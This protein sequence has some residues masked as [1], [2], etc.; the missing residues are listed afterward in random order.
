MDVTGVEPWLNKD[1]SQ[2]KCGHQMMKTCM[3]IYFWAWPQQTQVDLIKDVFTRDLASSKW[4]W[5]KHGP[6]GHSVVGPVWNGS[7]SGLHIQVLD[8][9]WTVSGLKVLWI[10]AVARLVQFA[11]VRNGSSLALCKHS[12][13]HCNYRQVMAKLTCKWMQT[14]NLHWYL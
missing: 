2:H 9:F 12:L 4:I 10:Q 8:P 1:T 7:E 6:V 11:L 14:G 5:S 13:S 3:W